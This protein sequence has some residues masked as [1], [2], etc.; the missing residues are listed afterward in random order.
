MLSTTQKLA[1][2]LTMACAALTAIVAPAAHATIVTTT[3]GATTTYTENFNG[4]SSFSSGWFNAPLNGDDYMW[5]TALDPVS[6]FT[7][8]S[9]TP[10]SNL[11]LSFWYAVPGSDSGEVTFANSGTVSLGDT[12]GNAVQFL[13]NNPGS[14]TGGIGGGFDSQF[15]GSLQNLGAGIYTISLSTAGHLL[16]GLKVDD[17]V[18]TTTSAATVDVPEPA[19]LAI[20]GIGMLGI[21]LASR[22]KNGRKSATQFSKSAA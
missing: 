1:R 19:S 16:D 22:R 14:S 21:G 6:S 7:F 12:P 20:L 3:S 9:L 8:S 2:V 11:S 18:I 17:L 10:L 13:L 5:L 15:F 4:G